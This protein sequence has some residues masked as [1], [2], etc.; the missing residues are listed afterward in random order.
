MQLLAAV[1]RAEEWTAGNWVT[2]LLLLAVIVVIIAF[3][4][5]VTLRR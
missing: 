1:H 4:V 3:A 2:G 5:R